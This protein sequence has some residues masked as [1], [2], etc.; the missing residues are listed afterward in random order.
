MRCQIAISPVWMRSASSAEITNM[1]SCVL[2]RRRRLSRRSASTPATGEKKSIGRPMATPTNPQD[3]GGPAEVVCQ[4][5]PRNDGDLQAAKRDEHAEPHVA[6]CRDRQ[7]V[8]GLGDE[9]QPQYAFAACL[10]LSG[11]VGTSLLP[12]RAR[13]F[14]CA[15]LKSNPPRRRLVRSPLRFTLCGA[16]RAGSFCP[17]T[18][19]RTR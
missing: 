14:Q 2:I 11:R 1:K 13:I 18:F 15:C 16:L 19:L 9:L 3:A 17:T 8:E 10:G 5:P 12:C 4:I 7:R 6:K